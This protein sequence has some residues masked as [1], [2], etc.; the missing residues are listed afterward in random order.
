MQKIY[1]Q[2]TVAYGV[3]AVILLFLLGMHTGNYPTMSFAVL[4]AGSSYLSMMFL[5][6]GTDSE[7][8]SKP[9][10][11]QYNVIFMMVAILLW[12][13]GFGFNVWS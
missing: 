11:V 12:L 3:L 5:T 10:A 13:V 1:G 9:W 4:S 7:D 2:A 6:A 8:L